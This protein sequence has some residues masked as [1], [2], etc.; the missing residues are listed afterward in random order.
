MLCFR[1][2]LCLEQKQSPIFRKSMTS[3]RRTDDATDDALLFARFLEGDDRAFT[4]LLDRHNRRLFAYTL[5]M[6][7][8]EESARDL[9]QEVWE[10]VIRMRANPQQVE[11]P[12][13]LLMRIVRNLS[14][15]RIRDR[16]HHTSLD[17]LTLA[18]HPSV[19]NHDPSYL[20]E[21][22]VM[23]LDRLPI[24]QREVLILH[25]YSG[26]DYTE[27]A[28]MLERPADSIR[29]RAM[30]GRAHLARITAAL[31]AVEDERVRS[32]L[33]DGDDSSSEVYP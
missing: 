16:R 13:G 31:V 20:E 19:S 22:I 4:I 10:R 32:L 26:Y 7:G 21:L 9:M 29:M 12:A 5:K 30:R 24:A 28:R 23:A 8:D 17:D 11:N 15:N 33:D 2:L 6:L 27:I 1:S 14:L 18:N 25:V 3:R